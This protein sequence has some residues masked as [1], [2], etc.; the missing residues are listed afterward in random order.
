SSPTSQPTARTHSA[1]ARKGFARAA[2]LLG[3]PSEGLRLRAHHGTCLLP[4]ERAH[5]PA[6][7][8]GEVDRELE[9]GAGG[10]G[11]DGV[12]RGRPDTGRGG[13]PRE[14]AAVVVPLGDLILGG[15]QARLL[16]LITGADRRGT[17]TGRVPGWGGSPPDRS[18]R[19]W[20]ASSATVMAAAKR[21]SSRLPVLSGRI[22]TK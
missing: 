4:H 11:G 2:L 20:N 18:Q 15:R 14:G 5:D 10:S 3:Q 12:R 17:W 9:A 19:P 13:D 22:V 1:P 6:E 8:P 16:Q 21:Q 7:R